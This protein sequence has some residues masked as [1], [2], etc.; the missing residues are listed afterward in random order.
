MGLTVKRTT[1]KLNGKKLTLRHK[2]SETFSTFMNQ[3]QLSNVAP[4]WAG[5]S[6]FAAV[7]ISSTN[8]NVLRNNG[9]ENSISMVHVRPD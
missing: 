2:R 3:D 9:R 6:N 7:Q 5:V 1:K 4:K 8:F